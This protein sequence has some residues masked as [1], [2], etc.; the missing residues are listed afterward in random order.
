VNE[1]GLYLLPNLLASQDQWAN[2]LPK[3]VED[4]VVHLDAL[5]AESKKAGRRFLQHFLPRS[6]RD[7]PIHLLNEHSSSTE[8]CTLVEEI[9]QG[10]RWGLVSDAG[11]P[12]LA[13]PGAELVLE[14]Q[15]KGIGIRTLAGPSAISFA[16]LLSGLGGQSF[17][18]HGYLPIQRKRTFLK[19]MEQRSREEASTQIF[20]ETPYRNQHSFKEL[21]SIL[22]KNTYLS[23]AVDL[24]L[25]TEWVCTQSVEKW[26]I[27][28]TPNLQKRPCVFLIRS[29]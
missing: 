12:C 26:R 17:A 4:I 27:S 21:V 15:Q 3:K 29:L 11:L 14:L 20:I 16:L 25:P 2:F 13:D 19:V 23:C 8:M 10:G 18:F 9:G 1:C 6:F 24:T 7:L 22:R 28:P 5:I